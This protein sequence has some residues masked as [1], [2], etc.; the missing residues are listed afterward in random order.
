MDSEKQKHKAE[1]L[2]EMQKLPVESEAKWWR[3]TAIKL[4]D[5]YRRKYY[6]DDLRKALEDAVD[7]CK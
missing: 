4:A 5:I 1:V 2:P 6:H 7:G 3:E